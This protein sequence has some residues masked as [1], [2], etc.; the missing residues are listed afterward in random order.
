[1]K[2]FLYITFLLICSFIALQFCESLV[3]YTE[4]EERRVFVEAIVEQCNIFG[5]VV[6]DSSTYLCKNTYKD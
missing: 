5:E 4:Q 2:T 3:K 6:I 1:M